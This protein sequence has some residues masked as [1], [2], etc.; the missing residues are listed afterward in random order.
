VRLPFPESIRFVPAVLFAMILCLIQLVQGTNPTFAL[1]CFCYILV[2]TIAFNVAGGFTRTS[3]SFIFFNSVLG[4]IVGLCVKVYL[5]EPADSNLAAPLLTIG[6]YLF[7]MCMML[8]AVYLSKRLRPKQ[9]IM[10]RMVTDSNMQTATVGCLVAGIAIQ[11]AGYVIPWGAGSVLSA[12]NQLNRFFPLAII[13][14]VINTI[15]RSGG[16]RSVNL[17]V[18]L[19]A[20]LSFTVGVLGFSKEGMLA[21]FAA[22]LVA[23]ASQRYRV[24]RSQIVLG[25]LAIIFVFRYLVPYAQYGRTFREESAE[26]N[27]QV[28]LSLLSDP[29][30]VREQYLETSAAANEDSVL[31]Y[32]NKPQGFFDRLQMIS[33]DDALI[34]RTDQFGT[35]GIMPI[36]YAFENVVPHFIWRDKPLVLAGNIYAHE[37]GVLSEGDTST[38]VSFSSTAS[39]FHLLGWKGI[40]FIGPALW[41]SLFLIFD[42][43]C[44]DVRKTPWGLLVTVL[45][46]H[47]APEGDIGTIVYMCFYTTYAIIFAGIMGAYVMPIIGT[48]FIGPEGI[49][50]RR[51]PPIRS[52]P[53]RLQ[54]TTPFQP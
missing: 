50:I 54:P 38:G 8:V 10:G 23:A 37:V 13:L 21:P 43:L 2:A 35:Y 33:I 12:L 40:F 53:N 25:V 9:A 7:G 31:G 1:C 34:H 32:F 30:Y 52:I 19:A 29:G 47:A 4:V 41:F 48:F 45:F 22:Y 17:P 28:S 51:G 26:A 27:L 11:F 14:G 44:G 15:R 46:A 36:I 5:G 42:S 16:R 18:L 6:V 24:S 39:S 20:A 3:G 49:M